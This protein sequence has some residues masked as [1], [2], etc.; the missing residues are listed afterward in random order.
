MDYHSAKTC[1]AFH[2]D[3]SLVRGIMGPIGSGKSVACT[4]E[5]F[6][7]ACNQKPYNGCRK[8]RFAIIRNT[9]GELKTTTVKT[10]Q[11][12]IPEHLCTIVNDSPIRGTM[13]CPHPSGDGTWVEAE[14]LFVSMDKPKDVRKVLSLELTGAWINEAREI[15]KSIVDA[16]QSRLG[17]YPGVNNGGCTKKMLI[18]DTNP[19][20][21]DHW[22][23][24][25]SEIERPEGWKFFRQPGGIMF[26]VDEK[27]YIANPTA[28]NIEN[29]PDGHRYYLDQV[30]GKDRDWIKVYLEGDYGSLFTGKPVYEHYFSSRLHVSEEPLDFYPSL[31]LILGWDYGHT[32]SC[33]VAQ[34][35]PDGQLRIL[36]ELFLEGA[37]VR[38]FAQD[39]VL[40][41]LNNDFSGYKFNSW[42]DPAGAVGSQHNIDVSCE[43]ELASLGIPTRSAGN[44]QFHYRRQAVID[45]LSKQLGEKPGLIL[46]P[47]CTMLYQ[48]FNGGYQYSRI[49]VS[50]E[51]RYK[52]VPTKNKFS[53]PADALQYL[54]LGAKGGVTSN[55]VR[56]EA[57]KQHNTWKATVA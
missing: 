20:D 35:S 25:M 43:T 1:T 22:W 53:H 13:R 45:F 16:V 26:D 49:Q 33:I 23:F 52:E 54:C 18:M 2:K 42:G 29:L 8:T 27:K 36:R 39:H 14:F 31:P 28:E 32:P 4:V 21:N 17:R 9:Y 15:D 57:P 30:G 51:E 7:A 44:N 40:P 5:L 3:T 10:F 6:L 34:L 38:Q 47:S 56:R 24:R 48:G 19:P 11:D 50:G 46:D 12:W 55:E 37:G 41:L